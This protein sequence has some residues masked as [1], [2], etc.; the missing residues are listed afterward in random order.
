[1]SHLEAEVFVLIPAY[2]EEFGILN[3]IETLPK[4]VDKIIVVDDGSSDN[5]INE[6]K[7]STRDVKLIALEKNKGKGNAL[8]SG[9]IWLQE[10]ALNNA[11]NLRTS[12]LVFVDGDGQM[13]PS[14]MKSMIEPIITKKGKF[15]KA[16]RFHSSA[17]NETMPKFRKIGNVL[18]RYLNRISTGQWNITDPQ[19]GYYA[20]SFDLLVKFD[21]NNFDFGFFVEN[22]FLLE[23]RRIRESVIE[24]SIPAI[25]DIGEISHINYFSFIPATSVKLLIEWIGRIIYTGNQS[26]YRFFSALSLIF[27]FIPI[28][29]YILFFPTLSLKVYVVLLNVV[30]FCFTMFF[31]FLDFSQ[32]NKH[33]YRY[34]DTVRKSIV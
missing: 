30:F 21:F 17:H 20:V 25:Y 32:S 22:S 5:T 15:T 28:I 31:D 8:I 24:V 34:L 18:L 3:T 16:T 13:P 19:N 7:K 23:A 12:I 11:I 33:K 14:H 1:M 10:Y 9:M 27:A 26:F 29:F 2:N 4:F 6:I